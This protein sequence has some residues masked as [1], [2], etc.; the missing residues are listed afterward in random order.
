M[1]GMVE[2]WLVG[3]M[4]VRDL[5]ITVLRMVAIHRGHHV[6]TSQLAKWKTMLQLVLIFG[7]LVFMNVRVVTAKLASQPVVLVGNVSYLVLNGL[8][9]SVTILAVVS[10]V[11]YLIENRKTL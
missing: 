11:R 3:A 9:A 8:V 7:I 2:A 4:L 5:V 1:L 10:G 6:V